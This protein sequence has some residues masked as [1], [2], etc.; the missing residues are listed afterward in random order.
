MKKIALVIVASLGF[1]GMAHAATVSQTVDLLQSGVDVGDVTVI[2]G[3][4]STG[5]RVTVD[6][7]LLTTNNIYQILVR[8]YN[9]PQYCATPYDCTASV[10][11]PAN[12]GN[13]RIEATQFLIAAGAATATNNLFFGRFYRNPEGIAALPQVIQGN[14]ATSMLDAQFQI[15]LRN[16]GPRQVSAVVFD[17]LTDFQAGGECGVSLTCNTFANSDLIEAP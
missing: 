15:E 12:G 14:G 7:G 17:Q 5:V 16:V 2:R 3:G 10:D 13:T 11:L 8:M 4:L 1:G 6:D 9:K